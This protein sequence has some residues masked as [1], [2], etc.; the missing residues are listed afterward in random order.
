MYNFFIYLYYDRIWS[1]RVFY[2]VGVNCG[3]FGVLINGVLDFFGIWYEDVVI[4]IC[5]VGYNIIGDVNCRC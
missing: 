1:Y 4:Y 2:V 5:N 3:D